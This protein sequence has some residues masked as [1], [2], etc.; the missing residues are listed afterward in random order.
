MRIGWPN[1]TTALGA[2]L[3]N[4]ADVT[5]S[6]QIQSGSNP[7]LKSEI[8]NSWTFGAVIQ[9]RWIPGLSLTVSSYNIRVTNVIA[10]LSAQWIV[11]SCYDP[12]KSEQPI[13][14]PVLA[15]PGSGRGSGW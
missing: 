6:L 13:L 14:L 1:C 7:S 10:A 8:S 2:N 12:A 4:L 9:P 5:G 15:L 3:A 11:N